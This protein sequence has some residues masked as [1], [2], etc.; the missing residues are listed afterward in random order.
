MFA[1]G[2]I[3]DRAAVVVPGRIDVDDIVAFVWKRRHDEMR[4]RRAP[5]GKPSRVAAILHRSS[6]AATSAP[7]SVAIT[8]TASFWIQRTPP[9]IVVAEPQ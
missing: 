1:G 4:G 3:L 2:R 8:L 5:R 6:N 9:R 7:Q